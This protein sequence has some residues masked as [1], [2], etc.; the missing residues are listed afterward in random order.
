MNISKLILLA[1]IV[2]SLSTAAFATGQEPDKIV[3]KGVERSLFSNPLEDYYKRPEDRPKFA[4]G[5]FMF[6]SGNW[7]GY[8][9]T[10]KI[11]NG[12]LFLTKIDSWI[13]TGDSKESCHLVELAE[14]FP[15]KLQ[16]GL[17]MADWYT[18][19]LR[20]PDGKEL[21]YVHMGYGSIYERDLIFKVKDG[22]VGEPMIIDNTK[23]QIPS[24]NERALEEL[25][26]LKDS[27]IGSQPAFGG[28]GRK[29][30]SQASAKREPKSGSVIVPG[31][32][33]FKVGT[34]RSDL[35]AVIGDGEAG[36][37]YDDVYF[38]EY[39]KVGVQVSYKNGTDTVHV[40]FLYNGPQARY[41]D[42][43]APV[44]KTDKG[45]DWNSTDKDVL[46][47]YGKP[48]K[49]F[50]DDRK[51]WRRL[52]YP[53]IDFLFSSGRLSRIGILGTNSN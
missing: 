51:T 16:E 9:A 21:R 25:R 49:D 53:G 8:V 2:F 22:E 48:S 38:V 20:V 26:K 24:A 17:V 23:K 28:L 41:E 43:I 18:G 39:P 5:P 27:S 14:L 33:V 44:V 1:L 47:A 52:E 29:P 36:S 34:K 50:S 40:I 15:K 4:I 37:K 6:S 11:D 12:K 42:F 10:W 13:C 3:Y 46:K 31:E 32:G 7:R 19:D 45:I 35:E 30:A